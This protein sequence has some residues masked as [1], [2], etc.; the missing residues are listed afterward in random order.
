MQIASRRS[1]RV[2]RVLD[3]L[4]TCWRERHRYQVAAV[5][6]YSGPAF[7]WA[8]AVC[9]M[10]RQTGK[11]YILM[12]H[13]GNLPK[14]AARRPKLVRQLLAS[15][16]AVTAPSEYLR[17]RMRPY[18]KDF[19]VL[20]NAIPI[21]AYAFRIRRRATRLIWLRAF[22]EVYN[23]VM[24]VR[25]LAVLKRDFSDIQLTMIGTDKG[26]GS[27][28]RTR[29]A[30]EQLGVMDRLTL[31]GGVQK[32]DVP[33][34]LAGA[35]VFLNT[36][37]IDNTPVSVLEAMASGLCVVSTDVGGIP[38]LVRAEQEALL[39]SPDNAEAMAEAVRRI[40][41]DPQLSQRLCLNARR[42]VEQLD[43]AVVLPRWEK[44]LSSV[45]QLGSTSSDDQRNP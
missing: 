8:R 14:F 15:A 7:F 26:D 9:W 40:I 25:A 2:G 12:L 36:A 11:P 28:A 24:A 23:P 27:L 30:A 21:D 39:V 37:R 18:W 22:H 35:D 1:S 33:E 44:L 20:P 16:A 42:K 43:W 5:D 32:K 45:V 6:L 29:Q 34:K 19:Q 31:L 17:E 41:V 38:Y 10:L 3:M 13:G 4:W